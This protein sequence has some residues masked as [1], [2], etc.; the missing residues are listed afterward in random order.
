MLTL[1]AK[2]L[3]ILNSDARPIQI[4]LAIALAM[5]AGLNSLFSLIGVFTLITLFL[6]RANLSTYFALTALF[7]LLSI[8]VAPMLSGVGES[9]LTAQA[10]LPLF[11]ELYNQDWFRLFGFNNTLVMGS[12]LV[13]L[14]LFVPVLLA[15]KVLVVKY[16][17]ALMAFVNKFKVVQT[18]KASKFY[19]IYESVKG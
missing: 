16:R 9:V 1:L 4:A 2:L 8:A 18:L 6:V 14:I 11:T 7:S 12:A 17:E 10:L 5:L 19:Q 15:C 3:N 13:S